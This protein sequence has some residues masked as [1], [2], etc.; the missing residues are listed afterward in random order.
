MF[1]NIPQELKLL[2]QWVCW[3]AI[4]DDSRPGK[5]KK[6][7]INAK[8]G[9]QAQSNNVDTWADFSTAYVEAQKYNGIGFMFANGYFFFFI[10]LY[11]KFFL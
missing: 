4:D 6:I 2:K 3:K 10:R 7:P 11:F 9:G 5:I 8:T 1:E